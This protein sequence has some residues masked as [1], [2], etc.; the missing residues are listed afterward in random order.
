MN[1]PVTEN[2]LWNVEYRLNIATNLGTTQPPAGENWFAA[3][4]SVNVQTSPPTAQTG[5]QYVLLGWTGTGSVPASGTSSSVAFT[6]ISPSS[7]TWNWKTQYYLIV[8]SSYGSTMDWLA[9]RR[10]IGL[11]ND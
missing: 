8:S 9:G 3:G 10:N 2:A 5:A 7:I 1:G 4:T 6:I 11:R